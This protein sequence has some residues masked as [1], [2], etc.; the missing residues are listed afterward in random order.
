MKRT[1]LMLLLAILW[2]IGHSQETTTA[3]YKPQYTVYLKNGNIVNG[4]LLEYVQGDHITIEMEHH[5]SV[6]YTQDEIKKITKSEK[7]IASKELVNKTEKIE[8][9]Y[10][11]TSPLGVKMG[12][13]KSNHFKSGI[14][15][16]FGYN[17][18][19]LGMYRFNFIGQFFNN[20]IQRIGIGVGY[21]RYAVVK[22]SYVPV[23]AT[24]KS[25]LGKYNNGL[26]VGLDVGYSF[27]E[28]IS[29]L[30]MY[31]HPNIGVGFQLSK[32]N[33]MQIMV[34]YD[35]QRGVPLWLN[36]DTPPLAFSVGITF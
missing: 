13:Y 30:G 2:N 29:P 31:L 10:Y 33:L 35:V 23:F 5:K 14:Q 4:T 12:K 16:D 7:L 9:G 17:F 18:G 34:G 26:F 19:T 8:R 15:L 1:I 11:P 20:D 3:T 32:F 6:T 28:G 21:R 22:A 24:I 36:E 27:Y 25:K